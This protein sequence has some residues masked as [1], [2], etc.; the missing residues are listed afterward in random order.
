[1]TVIALFGVRM[2]FVERPD[3]TQTFGEVSEA[4]PRWVQVG[5]SGFRGDVLSLVLNSVVSFALV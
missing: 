2:E 3:A 4:M 1:M 5:S